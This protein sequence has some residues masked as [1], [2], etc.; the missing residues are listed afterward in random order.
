MS[1]RLGCPHT[2]RAH[3]PRLFLLGTD[4]E[5][6][7]NSSNTESPQP[8]PIDLT[9]SPVIVPDPLPANV[10]QSHTQVSPAIQLLDIGPPPLPPHVA[11][12]SVPRLQTTYAPSQPPSIVCLATLGAN[13]RTSGPEFL[14]NVMW[15]VRSESLEVTAQGLLAFIIQSRHKPNGP[16]ITPPDLPTHFRLI[17]DSVRLEE[18]WTMHWVFRTYVFSL[19]VRWMILT[20]YLHSGRS[21]DAMGDG[22]TRQVL[23]EAIRIACSRTC[24]DVQST[25]DGFVFLQVDEFPDADLEDYAFALGVLSTM[26]LLRVHSA[27][28][29]ISPALLQVAIGG[30]NSLVDSAWLEAVL[31]D[32]YNVLKLFPSSADAAQ[33]FSHLHPKEVQDL[34]RILCHVGKQNVCV[35]DSHFP[36]HH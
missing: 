11:L 10:H 15:H 14:Q 25:E 27:P 35:D 18:V 9:E 28:L 22:V 17:P 20:Y 1:C 8:S 31:P 30:I 29:P 16:F 26:F 2:S 12:P 24:Q 7:D 19:I 32:T 5:L 6:D 3:R 33:D 13:V 34:M 4:D 36:I 23:S 21:S